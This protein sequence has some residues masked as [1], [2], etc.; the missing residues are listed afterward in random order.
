MSEWHIEFSFRKA[1]CIFFKIANS[2][3]FSFKITTSYH[4]PNNICPMNNIPLTH[5]TI[6]E[7]VLTN[8][9]KCS[10]VLVIRFTC[11]TQMVT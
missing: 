7:S 3:S 2:Q 1:I 6:S 11:F 9:T 4:H 5:G 8:Q 10:C